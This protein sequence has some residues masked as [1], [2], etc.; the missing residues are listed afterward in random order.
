MKI[1]DI[2]RFI[3]NL[4]MITEST[5][6]T[7]IRK[8]I[9]GKGNPIRITDD[10]DEWFSINKEKFLILLNSI[11]GPNASGNIKS[12]SNFDT[13]KYFTEEKPKKLKAKSLSDALIREI[14]AIEAR[15]DYASNK[16]NTSL[17]N[18]FEMEE[19][20]PGISIFA[21]YT[22][23][24][25]VYLS[26]K[27]LK[28]PT[29]VTPTWCIASPNSANKMWS[30]YKL[31]ESEYPAVFIV[32]KTNEN[33]FYD[34]FKYEL[35]CDPLK[36]KAFVDGDITLQ[37]LVD[38][39]R[40][41]EQKEEKISSSSLFKRFKISRNEVSTAIKNLMTSEKGQ[42]FSKKYGKKMFE[43]YKKNINS[44][45]DDEI[46][47]NFLLKACQ[48]GTFSDFTNKVKPDEKDFF[49]KRLMDYNNLFEDDIIKLQVSPSKKVIDYLIKNKRCTN[50]S[51][52]W[53]INL[54][55][56][57]YGFKVYKSMDDDVIDGFTFYSF[58]NKKEIIKKSLEIDKV[59]TSLMAVS[60]NND[61]EYFDAIFDRMEEKNLIDNK[62]YRFFYNNRKTP[63]TEESKIRCLNAL[64]K[65]DKVDSETLSFIYGNN[66]YK[67]S[68]E[69]EKAM[70]HL[71]KSKNVNQEVY[72]YALRYN[73]SQYADECLNLL[74]KNG[75]INVNTLDYTAIYNPDRDGKSAEKVLK[76]L[77]KQNKISQKLLKIVSKKQILQKYLPKITSYLINNDK[78]SPKDANTL[79]FDRA[80]C[81]TDDCVRGIISYSKKEGRHLDYLLKD[82]MEYS[83]DRKTLDA[84][85][86]SFIKYDVYSEEILRYILFKRTSSKMKEFLDAKIKNNKVSKETLKSLIKYGDKNL[87]EKVVK[88][89]VKLDKID[90]FVIY[91]FLE[92]GGFKDITL[93]LI[94]LL[95]RKNKF[96]DKCFK[97][98]V[99]YD[100]EEMIK[101]G[102][103]AIMKNGN[104]TSE[105]FKIILKTKN[106]SL[107]KSS[108]KYILDNGIS[109]NSI[110]SSLIEVG[111]EK[112]I[113]SVLDNMEKMDNLNSGTLY[114]F[115]ETDKKTFNR[116]F[117]YMMKHDKFNITD[118][119]LLSLY[120]KYD[121]ASA[122]IKH[123]VDKGIS[124]EKM[125]EA[126]RNNQKLIEEIENYS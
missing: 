45:D 88:S 70:E 75:D 13:T 11:V 112:Y 80:T 110:I 114:H 4:K 61:M 1:A 63:N 74:M 2:R 101:P 89:L 34:D 111:E 37:Q 119:T 55:G 36:T 19:I 26:H 109:S 97:V 3:T 82:M 90:F 102:L 99:A 10:E 115:I 72:V 59:N 35:K 93:N 66:R 38:E 124:K 100:V 29:S 33:G 125:K 7:D 65:N 96:D 91:D 25:N 79:L 103:K 54:G 51:I 126:V 42:D 5:P 24:A 15:D 118:L 17:E 43:K 92:D 18:Q 44:K 48:N 39:W 68:E 78:F 46:R 87:V 69:F 22:P 106:Q 76:Y 73:G 81:V 105:T 86:G 21:V 52:D 23:L 122:V 95:I 14:K 27:L 104:F 32:T 77:L 49:I 107:I 113:P 67:K 31:Y 108:I 6:L 47:F 60:F 9:I 41:P 20:K 58:K 83:R 28:S 117:E 12:L 120:K 62:T 71:I 98:V 116:L 84:L 16:S 57:D 50:Y 94:K 53:A 56:E 123:F 30:Y 8:S 40:D 64:I 85:I 121:C